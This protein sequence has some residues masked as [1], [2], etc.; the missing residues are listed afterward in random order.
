[1]TRRF[2]SLCGLAAV[3]AA[4]LATPAGAEVSLPA[5]FSDHMVLQRE[6]A[7]RIFGRAAP[8]EE[9]SVAFRG[10]RKQVVAGADGGWRVTLEP[11]A[12]GGPD[13]LV[14]AG[15]ST[16]TLRDVL[17]GEVWVGSGQSN[18]A[19]RASGYAKNDPELERRIAAGPHPRLR[20]LTVGDRWTEATPTTAA[21]FSA[22]LFGY[23]WKLADE[24]D[25]PVGLILG[26]VGGTPSGAWLS[27]A[28]L[29]A[30][31]DCQRQLA[32]FAATWNAADEERRHAHQVAAWER[33]AAA[34]KAAGRKEPR[35][36]HPLSAPGMV[37]GQKPGF[38]YEK[39]IRPVVGY[40]IRGVLWDQG[41]GGTGLGGVEQDTLMGGL[42]RGWRQEWGQGEFPFLYVQKPSGGGCRWDA[43]DPTTPRAEAFSALPATV[44]SD[45]GFVETHVRIMRQPRTAMVIAS[46]L[47]GG[48][49]PVDKS[50]YAD[51]AARVA[52]GFV[53][54]R[55][56]E[57]YGPLYDSHAVDG[58]TVRIHFTH[59]R[60]GLAFRHGE[61]LQGFAVAGE[62]RVFRFADAVIDG[63]TV[64]VSSPEVPQPV[65]VRYAWAQSRPWANLF[66]RDGLPAVPFRT[67]DWEVTHGS[68]R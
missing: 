20:L 40:T 65:A 44:P 67:D 38:L 46:D 47:G 10:Q 42:I 14:V 53:Y 9:V 2:L 21:G 29:A 22:L 32:A 35:R 27:E 63:A 56:L 7:V 61:R 52:L 19:G 4:G 16:I 57:Y 26:A 59:A 28:A 58:R 41:E 24:L 62:D 60:S 55:P 17:V 5:V 48:V 45:G 12:A 13:D 8:G 34:A 30:D 3:V 49:H 15:T 23:G 1:M 39:H 37:R 11:L 66:N 51:R 31:A 33:Q 64:V 25:V 54:Q 68:A 50:A 43:A 6:A 36:P 18:M